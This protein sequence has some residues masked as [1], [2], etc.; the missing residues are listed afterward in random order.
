[1]NS[2]DDTSFPRICNLS[3]APPLSTKSRWISHPLKEKIMSIQLKRPQIVTSHN[4]FQYRRFK[5]FLIFSTIFYEY[6]LMVFI[7]YTKANSFLKFPTELFFDE[8]EVHYSYRSDHKASLSRIHI[9]EF[10]P[11]LPSGDDHV[12]IDMF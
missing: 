3:M 5:S 10:I 11:C 7:F 6:V 1:M 2:S 8:K 12:W 4:A 9:C